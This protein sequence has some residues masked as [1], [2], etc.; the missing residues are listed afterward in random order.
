MHYLFRPNI[1]TLC[2]GVK[3]KHRCKVDLRWAT[4]PLNAT[5]FA[6]IHVNIR[7]HRLI[8]VGPQARKFAMPMHCSQHCSPSESRDSNVLGEMNDWL[9]LSCVFIIYATLTNR[10]HFYLRCLGKREW[11]STKIPDCS[12]DNTLSSALPPN[13]NIFIFYSCD[14]VNYG[15]NLTVLSDSFYCYLTL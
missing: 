15:L 6:Y 8:D 14:K 1:W 3:F 13:I 10:K 12:S 2:A 5:A 4:M 11:R 7:H 9:L